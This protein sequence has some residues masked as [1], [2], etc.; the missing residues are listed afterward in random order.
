MKKNKRIIFVNRFFYP[1]ISATS[2]VLSEL[3]FGL[4]ENAN[5][6][7]ILTSRS[8]YDDP[9]V[10]FPTSQ[11]MH[12]VEIIR[13]GRSRF[14]RTNYLGRLFDLA[15]FYLLLSVSLFKIVRADDVLIC[16]TDPPLLLVLGGLIKRIK[17]CQLIS[18][19][20]DLFPEIAAQYFNRF[21]LRLLYP[22]LY[23]LRN[24]AL[25][26][27]DQ[28][29]VIS[30]TMKSKLNALDIDRIHVITNWG[31]PIKA[32]FNK[33]R[34]LKKNWNLEDKFV[35]EY[36]GNFGFVHEYETIKNTIEL[37]KDNSDI[38]FLF[39]GSGIHNESLQKHTQ[40]SKLNNVIFKPYQAASDLCESLSLADLHLIT[41]RPQME[42]LMFPSKFY[43]ICAAARPVLFIGDSHGELADIIKSND[44][45]ECFDVGQAQ[46]LVDYLLKSSSDVEHLAKQGQN[47]RELFQQCYTLNHAQEK[48]QQV[49]EEK[50]T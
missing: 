26:R 48:W 46:Q 11:Q 10:V 19:N 49:L 1:D 38:V 37:L 35:V 47:A 9:A 50:R 2:Q 22:L 23:R 28:S 4:A 3:V 12:G 20:Q 39:I 27:C 6:I 32:D 36:S 34:A 41:F 14:A 33:V 42:G 13:V 43:S 45:G 18:W 44:C 21:G 8:A 40:A 7:M 31:K 24:S 15:G 25:K 29:V 16:K 5:S 17:K 30:T